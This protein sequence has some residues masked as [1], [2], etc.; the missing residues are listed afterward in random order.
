MTPE[1]HMPVP[2][3][4]LLLYV[5]WAVLLALVIVV[6]RS[7]KVMRGESMVQDFTSGVPHGSQAY[8]RANRAH[9]NTLE[10][11]P[12]FAAVILTAAVLK[13]PGTMFATLASVA[14]GARVVQSLVHLSSGSGIAVNIRFT[15]WFIQLL[16]IV[17]LLVL[18]V[19][20]AGFPEWPSGPDVW[21]QLKTGVVL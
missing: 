5:G 19:L 4:A 2:L 9:I 7:V 17:A 16:C 6:W 14:I 18:I 10:N 15:F 3:F 21:V 13:V 8:W 12:L 20:G 1:P 11:L